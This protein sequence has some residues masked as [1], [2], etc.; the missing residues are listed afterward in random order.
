[1]PRIERGQVAPASCETDA[2]GGSCDNH[3]GCPP[4]MSRVVRLVPELI[5]S[6]GFDV[7]RDESEIFINLFQKQSVIHKSTQIVFIEAGRSA[8]SNAGDAR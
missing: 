6:R 2:K 5:L 3:P 8:V 4:K 7:L 1:M